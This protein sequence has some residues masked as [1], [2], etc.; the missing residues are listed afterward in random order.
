MELRRNSRSNGH[1][2]RPRNEDS[3]RKA[4]SSPDFSQT[5]CVADPLP[6]VDLSPKQSPGAPYL[7]D[8][9]RCGIPRLLIEHSSPATDLDLQSDS[10]TLYLQG[11]R[12]V[13]SHICQKRADMGHPGFVSGTELLPADGHVIAKQTRASAPN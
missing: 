4:S 12:F 9:G 5:L 1:F 8:F 11:A 7:P 6:V 10:Y 13:E 2:L 3:A